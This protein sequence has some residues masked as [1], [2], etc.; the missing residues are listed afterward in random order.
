M[1]SWPRVQMNQPLV[2][3]VFFT[4]NIFVPKV[5]GLCPF[6][7]LKQFNYLYAYACFSRCLLSDRYGFLFSHEIMLFLLISKMCIYMFLLLSIIILHGYFGNTNLISGRFY[8]SGWLWTLGL[9]LLSL[10]PYSSIAITRVCVLLFTWTISW[11]VLNPQTCWQESSN[12]LWA[13]FWLILVYILNCPSLTVVSHSDFLFL[14]LCWNIVGMSV[15]LPS[16]KLHDIQQLAEALLQRQ[17]T[18][19]WQVMSFF[20]ARLPFVPLAMENFTNCTVMLR[21]T[22]WMFFTLWFIC[23]FAFC[24]SHSVL[25]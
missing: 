1:S 16:D 4:F 21:V 10:N 8:L 13:L 24:L 23:I 22:C 11:S 20:L 2:G 3:L 18:M 19:V 7:N 15:S 5:L 17:P 6:L 25:H 14:G 12:F 9:S